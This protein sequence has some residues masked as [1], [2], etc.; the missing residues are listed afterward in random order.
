MR[1]SQSS[2]SGPL[3]VGVEVATGAALASKR[4][5]IPVGCKPLIEVIEE[6]QS[7]AL[8][9]DVANAKMWNKPGDHLCC[10]IPKLSL[11][12]PAP[13]PKAGGQFGL[14]LNAKML[15]SLASIGPTD[16]AWITDDTRRELHN[17]FTRLP[18]RHIE[19]ILW[20]IHR[21]GLPV[22][23]SPPSN[24]TFRFR[25]ISLSET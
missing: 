2:G 7:G 4:W 21:A 12:G 10:A 22:R 20:A 24:A 9:E 25:G 16:T 17:S 1:C 5:D 19:L 23:V 15:A 3:W 11:E 13:H 14:A 6:K 8:Q 18:A